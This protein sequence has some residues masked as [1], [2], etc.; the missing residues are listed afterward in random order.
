MKKFQGEL[1]WHP[2]L[3]NVY[4]PAHLKTVCKGA[5]KGPKFSK[6]SL[7]STKLDQLYCFI[8]G[9]IILSRNLCRFI[10]GIHKFGPILSLHQCRKIFVWFFLSL[11]QWQKFWPAKLY[12]FIR[13]FSQK[14]CI[15]IAL[16]DTFLSIAAHHWSYMI[17]KIK[18]ISPI[19]KIFFILRTRNNRSSPH[20]GPIK[21]F[22]SKILLFLHN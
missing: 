16:N 15:C 8:A 7:Y 20:N 18:K 19:L 4:H 21:K 13:F 9:K 14:F 5:E 17:W 12:R 2:I 11:H 6:K 10:K 22:Y 3:R 1:A